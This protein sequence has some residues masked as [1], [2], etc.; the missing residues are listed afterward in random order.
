MGPLVPVFSFFDPKLA[1]SEEKT[2][3][4]KKFPANATKLSRND[5]TRRK[6]VGKKVQM[7]SKEE[8]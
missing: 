2:A 6:K 5:G 7:R 8:K 4:S 1:M 3:D